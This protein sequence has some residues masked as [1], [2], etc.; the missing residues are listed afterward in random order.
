MQS[1]EPIVLIWIY[2]NIESTKQL[3]SWIQSQPALDC[4][5]YIQIGSQKPRHITF[6]NRFI[7][8]QILSDAYHEQKV[9]ELK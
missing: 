6:K 9:W 8:E 7:W 1:R 5:G 3:L 4:L 2:N